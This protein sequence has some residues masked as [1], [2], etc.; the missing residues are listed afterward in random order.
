M[1][2]ELDN[3]E[4]ISQAIEVERKYQY[5]NILSIFK[6]IK[7]QIIT[8]HKILPAFILV[9]SSGYD[10]SFYNKNYPFCYLT[11]TAISYSP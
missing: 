1:V 7:S 5:I 6:E 10:L 4:Q 8:T 11:H 9:F 3:L 2:L